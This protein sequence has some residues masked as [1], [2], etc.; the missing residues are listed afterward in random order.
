MCEKG[1]NLIFFHLF[2][3]VKLVSILLFFA[4]YGHA[5]ML[6]NRSGTAFS[7]KPFFDRDFI[8][9]NKISQLKGQFTYKKPGEVM[10]STQFNYV[11]SF[12]TLGRLISSFETR[13]DDGTA[14]TTWNKYAYSNDHLLVEHWKGD[15]KGYNGV[16][17]TY[18]DQK[19]VIKEEYMSKYIDSLG[20]A[21]QTIINSEQMEYQSGDHQEK[22]KYLNSYGLP[23]ME[24]ITS[25]NN[26]GYLTERTKYYLMTS[27]QS[28][29]VFEYSD[30]GFLASIKTY[31][32]G[33]SELAEETKFEYD[34][35]GNLKEKQFHKKGKYIT[36]TEIL[37]NDK[38]H[39]LTYVITRDVA[40][41]FMMILGF[42]EYSF[43]GK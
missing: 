43:F 19:R 26:L 29:Q 39:L 10:R 21:H 36:E 27:A 37:Y 32:N 25:W 20:Q 30:K 22:K 1:N 2:C 24:E 38:S 14:D 8:L 6:D 3:F 16:R 15:K 31:E 17:Y 42:K 33:T 23:Y 35:F 11:Y 12:D 28:K 40:T 41:N 34:D 4:F 9:R 7:D 18:D 5:Q 13:K